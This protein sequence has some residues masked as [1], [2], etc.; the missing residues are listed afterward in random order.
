MANRELEYKLRNISVWVTGL[1][2]VLFGMSAQPASSERRVALV[3]GN[4]AYRSIGA[5]TNPTNDARLLATTLHSLGFILVGEGAQ[6]DLDRRGLERAI[7]AFG[8]ELS[9]GDVAFFFY[10][11]HGLQLRGSNYLVPVDAGPVSGADIVSHLINVELALQEMKKA[12]TRLNII[13]LDAC[14]NNPFDTAG[15]RS[16]SA[17]LAPMAA[18]E[19]TL[20][21]FATQ[22]GNVALDGDD[23]D[24]PFSK[25]LAATIRRPGIELFETFNEV[26]KSVLRET[27]GRQQP[28]ISTSPIVGSFYFAGSASAPGARK[29]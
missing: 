20:V 3:V 22:P 18:P 11:G 23:G 4:G 29:K 5:L 17:G 2:I 26:G 7:E 21:S 8:G 13:V 27:A 6:L 10:A 9:S 25:A 15:L 12:R 16:V 28:W 19:G 24:S 1:V 14:R